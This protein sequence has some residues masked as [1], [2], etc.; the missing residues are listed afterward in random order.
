MK[1]K[2][3]GIFRAIAVGVV[4]GVP[5]TLLIKSSNGQNGTTLLTNGQIYGFGALIWLLT[6]A[7]FT[8][9]GGII[10]VA[11]DLTDAAEPRELIRNDRKISVRMIAVTTCLLVVVATIGN[12]TINVS[13]IGSPFAGVLVGMFLV[14]LLNP[15]PSYV[16][17]RAYLALRRVLPWPLMDFLEDAH[18]RGI[19]RQA[20]AVYQFR[21]IDLQRRLATQYQAPPLRW[22][23]LAAQT[24]LIA[25]HARGIVIAPWL[26]ATVIP[27]EVKEPNGEVCKAESDL[28]FLQ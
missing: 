16:A 11:R 8:V 18:R 5:P 15:W 13:S 25:K 22:W 1:V 23:Q 2:F 21:H 28:T 17:G 19:L 20:G 14:G 4:I 24:K 27:Q 3:V 10:P 12:G 6:T 9:K 26:R 7:V